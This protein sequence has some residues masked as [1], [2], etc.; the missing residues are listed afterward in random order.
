MQVTGVIWLRDIVDKLWWKHHVTTDEV[1]E[2]FNHS[3]RYRFIESGDMMAKTSTR[4]SV[5]QK[6]VAISSSSSFTR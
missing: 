2:V 6:P 4:H 1:E 3:P 5:K